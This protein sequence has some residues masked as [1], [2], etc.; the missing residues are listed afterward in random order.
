MGELSP[1]MRVAK[2]LDTNKDG[3]LDKPEMRQAPEKATAQLELSGFKLVDKLKY[4][5]PKNSVPT[6]EQAATYFDKVLEARKLGTPLEEDVAAQRKVREE[7][8]DYDVD[9]EEKRREDYEAIISTIDS[10]DDGIISKGEFSVFQD[11]LMRLYGDNPGMK[12][13][14][15]SK[16][17]LYKM[18]DRNQ[19]GRVSVPEV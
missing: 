18:L 1:G 7:E 9:P 8:E 17:E 10:D 16:D 4:M 11:K 3:V 15:A 6:L 19:D 5:D 12:K 14:A 2:M 13:V